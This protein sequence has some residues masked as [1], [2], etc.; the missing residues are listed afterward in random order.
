MIKNSKRSCSTA[1]K[2]AL[3]VH[4]EIM[5]NPR[6]YHGDPLNYKQLSRGTGGH[7]KCKKSKF[8]FP[9]HITEKS[10]WPSMGQS[11]F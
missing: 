2:K 11:V 7:R 9:S 4:I 10:D 5:R 6:M 3:Q 8:S 1:D